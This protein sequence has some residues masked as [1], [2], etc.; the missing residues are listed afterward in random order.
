MD[1][2]IKSIVKRIQKKYIPKQRIEERKK[3][4][5]LAIEIITKNL[6]KL[7][8][9]HIRKI[10]ERLDT[11]F[12]KG[13]TIRRRFGLLV[14]GNLKR[15]LANDEKKMNL[16]FSEVFG[17]ENLDDV[18][19][20]ISDL[21]GIG[22]G[23]VSS[24][25]Y[26]KDRQGYNVFVNATSEGV[27]AAFPREPDFYGSFK[28]R[29]AC[30]NSLANELKKECDLE[31]QE[32]DIILTNLPSWIG[33][34]EERVFEEVPVELEVDVTKL[35]HS[36][37]QGILIEL[38]NL[39]RYKTYVA[40][41]SKPYRGKKLKDFATLSEIPQFT[42]PDT[43]KTAKDVDAIWFGADFPP[44]PVACFEVEHTTNVTGGLL[45]LYRLKGLGPKF[46]IIARSD[47]KHKF[48][49][50]VERTPF[51]EIKDRYIFRSYDQLVEFFGLAKRYH[52]L[53]KI[54][55]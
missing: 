23:F 27:K 30:F 38:G 55:L 36:D 3:Y 41:P 16:F 33:E 32:I 43:L 20:L 44:Y 40:D 25:L 13:R 49:S 28:D 54:F 11:D 4:E 48:E 19:V 46:F 24:M 1:S 45:R 2:K 18:E 12:W 17:K 26:L 42:Y 22:D 8:K 52:N 10:A 9:G 50:E 21:K 31:P 7:T 5:N 53:K 47:L 37:V 34:A 6:G 35:S 15:I 29:Y 39:L 14:W 51:Y